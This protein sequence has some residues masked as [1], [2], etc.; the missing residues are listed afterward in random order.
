MK[1]NE[2]N[3]RKISYLC[4]RDLVLMI[5]ALLAVEAHLDFSATELFIYGYN[6]RLEVCKCE[7]VLRRN[8][9]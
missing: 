9:P 4:G 7:T 6:E 2:R 1:I 8:D 3:R 5:M